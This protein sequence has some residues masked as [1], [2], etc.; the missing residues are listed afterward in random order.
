L[1]YAS[2]EKATAVSTLGLDGSLLDATTL[3]LTLTLPT[4]KQP[5]ASPQGLPQKNFWLDWFAAMV[6]DDQWSVNGD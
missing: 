1:T 6:L 5:N 4:S 2:P 3:K